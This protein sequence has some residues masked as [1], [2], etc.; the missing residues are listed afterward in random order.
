MKPKLVIWGASDHAMV[1]ADII[2][3]C[4]EY[5]LVGFL[6]DMNP[7]R[8]GAVF[9][10]STIIGGKEQLNELRRQ[11]VHHVIFGFGHAEARLLL[12]EHVRAQGFRLATAIHPH[13]VIAADVAIREGT[14]IKAGAVVDPDV[15]IGGNVIIGAGATIAHG[16]TLAKGVRISGGADLAGRVHIEEAAWI[17]VGAVIKN[18]VRIGARALIGAGAV[19]VEDIPEG[20]VG[21]GNPARVVR[22]VTIHDY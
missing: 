17:G 7:E 21:Y 4:E 22:K 3:L 10:G 14:V 13:A 11:G 12:A 16:S 6:D 1:V 18:H 15:T 5:E 2:R 9:F 20:M 8:H 19:V